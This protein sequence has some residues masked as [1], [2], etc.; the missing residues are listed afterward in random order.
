MAALADLLLELDIGVIADALPFIS[1]DFHVSD[2]LQEWIV[3]SMMVGAAIDALLARWLSFRFGREYSLLLAASTFVV[4]ALACAFA[5][6]PTIP[7]VARL[8]LGVAVGIATFTGPLYLSEIAA[9]NVRGAMV[10]TYQFMITV[11]ILAAFLSH[12]RSRRAVSGDGCS[13]S[14]PCQRGFFSW[15]C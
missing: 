12:R 9:G 2:R 3:S 6:N 7:V 1:K 8:V 13:A 4:G 10:S 15:A 14:L 5:P 11:G